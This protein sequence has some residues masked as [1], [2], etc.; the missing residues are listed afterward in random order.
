MGLLL[1]NTSSGKLQF[2]TWKI[3][4]T[5]SYFYQEIR[6]DEEKDNNNKYYWLNENKNK[7]EQ[8]WVW[9][10]PN[11]RDW[12]RL[13]KTKQYVTRDWTELVAREN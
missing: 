4:R 10:K 13:S 1:L 7:N 2:S 5:L 9:L 12:T 11:K 6:E 8:D 3:L